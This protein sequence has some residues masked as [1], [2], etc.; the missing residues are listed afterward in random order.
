MFPHGA[1][2][3]WHS[4]K[5][6]EVLIATDGIGLNQAE[7]GKLEVLLPGDVVYTKPG[8]SYWVGSAPWSTLAGIVI[9]PGSD[10]AVTWKEFPDAYGPLAN[11]KGDPAE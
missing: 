1:Y 8:V 6:G 4:H 7:G 10:T 9:H 5:S 3:A 11:G 2:S